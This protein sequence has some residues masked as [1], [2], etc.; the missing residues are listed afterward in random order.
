MHTT[1]KLNNFIL[2]PNTQ[3]NRWQIYEIIQGAKGPVYTVYDSKKK[4]PLLLKTFQIQSD[5]TREQFIKEATDWLQLV[6]H[7]NVIQARLL[8]N[9]GDIFYLGL[10]YVSGG[11]LKYWIRSNPRNQKQILLFAL[12]FCHAIKYL[13]ANGIQTQRSIKPQN[14]LITEDNV[15]KITDFGFSQRSLIHNVNANQALK[16]DNAIKKQRENKGFL[17][18]MAPEQFDNKDENDIRSDIYSFGILLYEMICGQPPFTAESYKEYAQ[19][20]QNASIPENPLFSMKRSPFLLEII[21]RCLLKQPEERY[22][23][24]NQ[25][26][27]DLE[28][29]YQELYNDS[30]PQPSMENRLDTYDLTNRGYALRKL[31]RYEEALSCYEQALLDNPTAAQI[32]YHK[33]YVLVN[34]NRLNEA[35]T[36]YDHA[37]ENNPDFAQA[38]YNKGFTLALMDNL[39]EA[40]SCFKESRKLGD[41]QAQQAITMCELMMNR[42][43]QTS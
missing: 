40:M 6:R 21:M 4:E 10:E 37:I 35:L 32:W 22:T 43:N 31:D 9:N 18:Y 13:K 2:D 33:G 15:L 27:Y 26:R 28:Q 20:H 25:V 42:I 1:Y 29:L 17:P 12:Q 19:K 30:A 23:D 7:E 5:P 16:K 38:W 11:N 14:C 8:K 3:K 34:L 39:P 24:F 36:C 41:L